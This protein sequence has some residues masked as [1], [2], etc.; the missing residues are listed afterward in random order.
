M[1]RPNP[2]LAIEEN[3]NRGKQWES[4]PCFISTEFLPSINAKP[5]AINPGYEIKIAN[6]LKIETNKIVCGGGLELEGHTFLIDLISFGHASRREP[7]KL[8]T[9]K[10]DEKKL[11][12]ILVV[13]NF[14][15]VFPEDLS[16]LPPS[17]EVEFRIDLI[18]GAMPIVKSPYRLAPTKMQELSNQL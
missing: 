9:I 10:V 2:V 5:S 7:K 16:G 3:H 15:G 12:D 18:P 13:R 17:R 14:P 4:A 8:K 11:K 6:G 1:Y